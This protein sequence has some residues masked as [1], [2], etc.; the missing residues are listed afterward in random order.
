MT[1][2][3]ILIGTASVGL[4]ITAS[5]ALAQTANMP[6]QDDSQRTAATA[7]Q[8]NPSGDALYRALGEQPGIARLMDD[9]VTRVMR[10][11]RIGH[12]FKNTK[13]DH[14]KA[15]LT[16][17]ICV[18]SGGPCEYKGASMQTAHAEMDIT[19]ADFNA[20]V[21]VLQTTMEAQAL[22]FARQRQLL[23]LLAPMHRDTITVR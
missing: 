13:P 2:I 4:L 21:E 12:H 11:P 20:L 10:D 5:L 17:Q 23:A 16:E 18:I 14:L 3:L 19:K 15:R 9:F 8:P 6:S 1:K 22:P 7:V